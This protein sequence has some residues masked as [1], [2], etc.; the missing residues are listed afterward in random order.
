MGLTFGCMKMVP[1]PGL[2][3]VGIHTAALQYECAWLFVGWVQTERTG[4]LQVFLQHN[5]FTIFG[6]E[7]RSDA[8]GSLLQIK[9]K[10]LE[11]A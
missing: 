8:L 3:E 11:L 6:R 9:K 2:N 4:S 7:T 5:P 1:E 10:Q